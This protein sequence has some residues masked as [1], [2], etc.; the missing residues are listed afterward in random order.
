VIWVPTLFSGLKYED[1]DKY[2]LSSL[3]R[4]TARRGLPGVRQVFSFNMR[5]HNGYGAE[6]MTTITTADDIE[7]ICGHRPPTPARHLQGGRPQGKTQAPGESES[8]V[9]GPPSL[10]AT[11]RTS[12]RTPRSST[13]TVFQ[14]SATWRRSTRRATSGSPVA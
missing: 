2:D 1:L 7:A 8:F 9:K 4:C 14:E 10:P 13:L 6:G 5:F 11:T 3:R 12:P